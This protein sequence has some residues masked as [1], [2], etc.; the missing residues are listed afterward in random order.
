MTKP[1]WSRLSTS[2]DPSADAEE[3]DEEMEGTYEQRWSEF[4]EG[5]ETRSQFLAELAVDR[6]DE[7]FARLKEALDR[8][9]EREQMEDE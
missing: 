5:S 8:L 4:T 6:S 9:I 7:E 2:F 3:N 1:D